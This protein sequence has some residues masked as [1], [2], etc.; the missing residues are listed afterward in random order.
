MKK[1][2]LFVFDTNLLV[3]AI[4]I[5]LSVSQRTL[6]KA[7]N[8]GKII[9]SEETFEELSEVLIRS[10]FDKY[11]PFNLRM[12]YLVK[13]KE[14]GIILSTKSNFR[15]CRDIKDNKFLNLAYDCNAY[16]I[17]SGD[18]DLLVLHPFENIPILSPADF[19]QLD[20]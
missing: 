11:I 9:F 17:V 15:L 19:L 5:P 12:E 14:T 18:N 4:L 20:L 7:E 13:L 3:S 1:I 10:K 6:S 8:I 16:C 2:N